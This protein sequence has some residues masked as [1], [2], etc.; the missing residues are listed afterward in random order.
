[1]GTEDSKNYNNN[2][3]SEFQLNTSYISSDLYSI[4]TS[5]SKEEENI[6]KKNHEEKN[7]N[8]SKITFEW[9]GGGNSVYLS[10]N[11][12]NWNQLFLMQKNA[13]GKFV[14]KLDI[15]NKGLIQYK[16]KVDNEWKINQNF[17][18]ILDNG[19]L[20]NYIDMNKL[21]NNKEKSEGNTDENT[22]SSSKYSSNN[23]NIKINKKRFGNYFPKDI[24][25]SIANIAPE[26]FWKM[27]NED[28]IN[29]IRKIENEKINHLNV[30]LKKN[31]YIENKNI[32]SNIIS[33]S[34]FSRYRSKYTNFIYIKNG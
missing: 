34:I 31:E 5:S 11:F 33:V 3:Y 30:G 18:S 15:N 1:M 28:N 14:L 21:D 9:T 10:G 17:P 23:K 16:F 7:N 4:K 32:H 24:D 19:N 25:L 8:K 6:N 2:N 26:N 27:R 12:C 13:E 29:N 22:E 20:N